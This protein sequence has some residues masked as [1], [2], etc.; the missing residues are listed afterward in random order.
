MMTNEMEPLTPLSGYIR[1][2][3][4]SEQEAV[5]LGC[6]ICTQLEAGAR[7]NAA[8]CGISP[9]TIFIHPSGGFRLSGLESAQKPG[10]VPE[11]L[12]Q[13][14]A[15]DYMAPEAAGGARYHAT[16][17]LY[18][19]GL[20]L[21]RLMNQNR[22][23]FLDAEDQMADPNERM[24]AFRRRMNGEPLPAPCDA[25]P[26][27]AAIILCACSPD[28]G[29]RFQSA[30][31]MK[32]ALMSVMPGYKPSGGLNGT[33]PPRDPYQTGKATDTSS[34]RPRKKSKLPIVLAAVLTAMLLIAGGIFVVPRLMNMDTGEDRAVDK[35]MD[36]AGQDRDREK[37]E[38]AAILSRAEKLAAENDFERAL[39]RVQAGLEIYPNSKQLQE[40]ADEY[41]AALR[42]QEE[43]AVYGETVTVEHD[44]SVY[45]HAVFTGLS[46]QGEAVWTYETGT[47]P[48][49]QLDIINDI[50]AY[51]GGYYL[52]EN[53]SIR[54]LNIADGS[55]RWVN[56]DF[57]GSASGS[58]FDSNGTLYLCGYLGPDLFIVDA[59]GNT[60]KQID[61]LDLDYVWP[62]QIEYQETQLAIT[63]EGTPSGEYEVLYVNLSDYST[64]RASGAPAPQ[65]PVTGGEEAPQVSMD[66]V[67]SVTA[68]SYLTEPKLGLVHDPSN[69]IDGSL[70][71]AWVEN[72]S[73]QGEG[74]SVTLQLNGTYTLSGFT[75]HAGYQKS[76]AAYE[77][78][79]R[80]SVLLVTFSDGGSVEVPL[81][82]VNRQ[83]T[84]TFDFA[85]E[86]SSV[87]FTIVSVYPGSKYEDT[88]ISE[89]SLF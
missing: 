81:E 83:Q 59:D 29:R 73:G 51:N 68:T 13:M 4:M 27:M 58:V 39:A 57:G 56:S 44:N 69:I 15:R 55:T 23:P 46:P 67:S 89:I 88:V 54:V 18:S 42:Q 22:L 85:V 72:A 3:T 52:V 45:E 64:A 86:T 10:G 70:S 1:G 63:F 61:S 32:N 12:S 35:S 11:G 71:N 37:E 2:R 34:H 40:K 26:A 77:N 75:I 50:G 66:A 74:E 87:T 31:A 53:G 60:I 24:A 25:S 79:S 38:I 5:K 30:A 41:T 33:A 8:H 80:P 82:D 36:A 65:E 17:D 78:N 48:A 7:G 62:F 43:Q 47:Y 84:V 14:D 76:A 9:E 20:V 28:P 21:Y 49:A 6:D 19:L 16:A